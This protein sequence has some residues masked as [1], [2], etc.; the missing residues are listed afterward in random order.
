MRRLCDARAILLVGLVI[1][2]LPGCGDRA[3]STDVPTLK[4][5]ETKF[6]NL[7]PR[8][9]VD[10]NLP[11]AMTI[12]PD[13]TRLVSDTTLG[14]ASRRDA[15]D[16]GHRR[17]ITAVVFSPDGKDLATAD[18][19]G[20][21][22]RWDVAEG[23]LR[24]TYQDGMG[25]IRALRFV[26]GGMTL[27]S[28]GDEAIFVFRD[29]KSG[30]ASHVPSGHTAE[31][32]RLVLSPD[33]KIL[34]SSGMDGTVRLWDVRSRSLR[35]CLKDHSMGVRALSFSLDGRT[36][37]GV[38]R[39]GQQVEW[40]T[41]TGRRNIEPRAEGSVTDFSMLASSPDG[42]QLALSASGELLVRGRADREAHRLDSPGEVT[43]ASFSPDGST[44]AAGCLVER[45]GSEPLGMI[46]LW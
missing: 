10:P 22:K 3:P 21:V 11:H 9:K 8:I 1:L 14:P 27:V 23:T 2:T 39:D 17:E 18:A 40:D 16:D 42:S 25:L 30:Q 26:D 4:A 34:A 5:A 41:E 43:C 20:V 33:G 31:V 44:F 29:L 37:S 36:L 19:D 15:G 38:N 12:S 6:P 46:V 7:R 28:A 13:G 35:S 45:P 24:A 32:S